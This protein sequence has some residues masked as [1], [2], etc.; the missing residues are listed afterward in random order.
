[1]RLAYLYFLQTVGSTSAV[2]WVLYSDQRH[3]LHVPCIIIH[4]MHDSLVLYETDGNNRKAYDMP[5][6]L[7]CDLL[8][9]AASPANG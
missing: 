6:Y 3:S 1:V 8:E 9:G 4:H 5:D 7:P 2:V